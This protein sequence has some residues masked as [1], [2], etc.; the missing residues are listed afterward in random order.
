M[1]TTTFHP[2]RVPSPVL[3]A[4]APGAGAAVDRAAVRGWDGE[5]VQVVDVLPEAPLHAPC[6]VS[7]RIRAA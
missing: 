4:G 1:L 3:D 2:H 7:V 5:A 6:S